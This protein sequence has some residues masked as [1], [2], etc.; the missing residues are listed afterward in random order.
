MVL[1]PDLQFGIGGEVRF[2]IKDPTKTS[3][4][5]FL[6]KTCRHAVHIAGVKQ[7][8]CAY[9]CSYIN[10]D[11][12]IPFPVL[13]CSRYNM[14]NSLSLAEMSNIAWVLEEKKR[15]GGIGFVSAAEWRKRNQFCSP[16][17]DI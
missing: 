4:G 5:E 16:I 6:C 11:K 3:N 14:I 12:P 2:N 17:D 13:E 7:G 9:Y 1:P 15:G 10:S 8:D